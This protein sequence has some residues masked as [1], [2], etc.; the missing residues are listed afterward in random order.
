MVIVPGNRLRRND[1]L[2]VYYDSMPPGVNENIEIVWLN[3]LSGRNLPAG[4]LENHG[5]APFPTGRI[6]SGLLPW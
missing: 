1:M 4:N 2:S 5:R 6:C 3:S